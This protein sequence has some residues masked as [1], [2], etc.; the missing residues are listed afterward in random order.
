MKTGIQR[1]LIHGSRVILKPKESVERANQD[2]KRHFTAMMFENVRQLLGKVR[3]PG[4]I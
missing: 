2:I 4:P 3:S 1:K